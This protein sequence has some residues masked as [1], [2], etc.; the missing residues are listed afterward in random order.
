MTREPQDP[1]AAKMS[2]KQ[3]FHLLP[4]SRC[5]VCVCL[6]QN[7]VIS[8]QTRADKHICRNSSSSRDG[9]LGGKRVG[10]GS[11]GRIGSRSGRHR[12][13]V[14]GS[15]HHQR[16]ISPPTPPHHHQPISAPQLSLIMAYP[17]ISQ[18]RYSLLCLTL[19]PFQF[20][21]CI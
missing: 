20:S 11:L 19:K 18:E 17:S 5:Q 15:H 12:L 6:F 14:V 8:L 13:T 7:L 10:L 3:E 1:R 9:L 21:F 2:K 16:T 4:H